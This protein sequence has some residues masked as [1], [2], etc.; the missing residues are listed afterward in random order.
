MTTLRLRERQLQQHSNMNQENKE[1]L[2]EKDA[3]IHALRYCTQIA[4]F[5]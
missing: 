4:F 1:L 3:L 2:N 5:L